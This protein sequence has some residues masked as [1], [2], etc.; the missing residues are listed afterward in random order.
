M[1]GHV[2]TPKLDQ[3]RR[4]TVFEGWF[5]FFAW[6]VLLMLAASP[7]A[8]WSWLS[9]AQPKGEHLQGCCFPGTHGKVTPWLCLWLLN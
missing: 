8:P 5:V 7:S 1:Q 2:Q 9:S 3:G 4:K 6:T